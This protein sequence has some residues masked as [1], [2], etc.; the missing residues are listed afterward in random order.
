MVLLSQVT[1]SSP[2]AALRKDGVVVVVATDKVVVTTS[3]EEVVEAL[4]ADFVPHAE[5]PKR[6]GSSS[7]A[8]FT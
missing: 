3:E 6:R 8:F 2:D 5:S 1:S 4:S 7:R